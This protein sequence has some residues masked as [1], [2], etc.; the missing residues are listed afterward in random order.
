[1]DLLIS[2]ILNSNNYNCKSVA[3]SSQGSHTGQLDFCNWV[4]DAI[5]VKINSLPF[6]LFA[7][8]FCFPI[9]LR[10]QAIFGKHSWTMLILL[11]WALT[12]IIY[13]CLIKL[14]NWRF[15]F[16]SRGPTSSLLRP[17]LPVHVLLQLLSVCYFI[18]FFFFFL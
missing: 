7:V 14:S 10:L 4:A 15:H 6:Q 3:Y 5:I 17:M 2:S 1:M 16:N 12:R 11:T 18:F 13:C 8:G 9:L